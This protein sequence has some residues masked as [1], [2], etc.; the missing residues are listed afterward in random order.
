MALAL[1]VGL[2]MAAGASAAVAP[3]FTRAAAQPG[4]RVGVIQPVRIGRP[5]HGHTGI[6]VYLIPLSRA[7]T[8]AEEGPPP[9]PLARFRLGELVGDRRGYWRLWFRVPD[10]P[11]GAYTTLVWC[12]PCGGSTYPRGSVFAGGFLAHNGVLHIRAA[13][14][15][16]YLVGPR[17]RLQAVKRAAAVTPQAALVALLRGASIHERRRG[18]FSDI[19]ATTRVQ[20]FSVSG[21]IATVLLRT[22]HAGPGAP[23]APTWDRLGGDD[24]YGTAQL[25][26][27]LTGFPSIKRVLLLVNGHHCCMS[28]MQNKPVRRPLTRAVF[29][30]WQGEP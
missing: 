25:V 8:G 6:T 24:V 1:L 28:T 12:R 30:G 20:R 3:V 10:V 23:T 14:C 27:T 22:P 26:Y 19:P 4:D 2:A 21:G 17:G 5:L 13:A 7:P 11:P 18:L 16:I 15:P 29:T 9:R